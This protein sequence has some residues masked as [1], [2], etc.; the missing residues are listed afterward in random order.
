MNRGLGPVDLERIGCLE[1]TPYGLE[2]LRQV[3]LDQLAPGQSRALTTDGGEFFGYLVEGAAV[4]RTADGA[5]FTIGAGTGI[6]LTRG[7]HASLTAT[8]TG[9]LFWVRSG[10]PGSA[11]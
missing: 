7:E 10:V 6:T 5:A 3:G 11:R 9:R 8:E 4:I 1:L 2:P